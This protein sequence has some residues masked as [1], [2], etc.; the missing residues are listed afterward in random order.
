MFVVN[1]VLVDLKAPPSADA[2]EWIKASLR[3][4]KK[5]RDVVAAAALNQSLILFPE[6][7]TRII[8]RKAA[9]KKWAESLPSWLY[10]KHREG[11]EKGGL[12]LASAAAKV[13]VYRMLRKAVVWDAVLQLRESY[14]SDADLAVRDAPI[15][16]I[17]GL[18]N[19]PLATDWGQKWLTSLLHYRLIHRLPTIVVAGISIATFTNLWGR[20]VGGILTDAH[21]LIVDKEVR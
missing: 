13:A 1:G 9:G 2:A 19:R 7:D 12:I 5:V 15:F 3:N 21:Q 11:D 14:G 20:S 18:G 17:A 8:T 4:D 16:A 6:A 10:I